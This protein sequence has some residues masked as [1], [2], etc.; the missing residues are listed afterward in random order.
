MP[1]E[2]F[3]PDGRPF[4]KGDRYHTY[5]RG[6][7][8]GAGMRGFRM[9]GY[10]DYDRGYGEGRDAARLAVDAFAREVG[11]KPSILRALDMP[12]ERDS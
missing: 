2:K 6:F 10:P 12:G 4:S 9:E 7:R 11:Y 3:T 5:A 1:D 8:D